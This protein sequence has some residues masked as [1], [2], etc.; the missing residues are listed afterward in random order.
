MPAKSTQGDAGGVILNDLKST[1]RLDKEYVSWQLS[2]YAWMFEKM[3]PGVPVE[4]LTATW[5]RGSE[6][7]YVAIERKDAS[8]V[9]ALL[10]ADLN[11]EPFDYYPDMGD[12]PDFIAK[13]VRI[14]ADIDQSMKNL[15]ARMDKIKSDILQRMGEAH[16]TSIKTDLATISRVAAS[17]KYDFD[18]DKFKAEHRDLYDQYCTK[19]VEKKESLTIRFK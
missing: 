5:L 12:V 19:V 8:L 3:N 2:I 7:E 16:A 4:G 13:N 6:G 17:S 15:K 18:K 14:L 9:E 10:K 11:D 1:Y